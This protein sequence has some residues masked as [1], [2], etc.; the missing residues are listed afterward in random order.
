VR[1]ARAHR[2]PKRRQV[3]CERL[4]TVTLG[5][6]LEEIG[7]EAFGYCTTL[8]QIVIPTA[9]KEIDDS[10]F[11][12]CSN[13]MNVMFCGEIEEFVFSEAIRV[14]WNQGVHEKCLS[15]F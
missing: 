9:V 8:Q 13:L 1:I 11:K 7:K 10:A 3:D 14:W 5:E 6:R 12:E 4:T 2:N 15:T